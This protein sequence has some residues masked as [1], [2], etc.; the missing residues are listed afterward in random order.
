MRFRNVFGFPIFWCQ[1]GSCSSSSSTRLEMA[2]KSSMLVIS[3]IA[4]KM[5]HKFFKTSLVSALHKVNLTMAPAKQRLSPPRVA[6]KHPMKRQMPVCWCHSTMVQESQKMTH[7][8]KSHS[9]VPLTPQCFVP[10]RSVPLLC[11]VLHSK[12]LRFAPLHSAALRATPLGGSSISEK[13]A[14][15]SRVAFVNLTQIQPTGCIRIGPIT[16]FFFYKDQ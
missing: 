8:S 11:A 1:S 16:L 2:S 13:V 14:M 10:L 15:Y 6:R 3:K 4:K 5:I 7:W 12:L 9:L